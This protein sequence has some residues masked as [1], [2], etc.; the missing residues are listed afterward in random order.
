MKFEQL[1]PKDSGNDDHL[2]PLINIV[3]LMLI[4]FMIAGQVAPSDPFT[5]QPPSSRVEEPAQLEEIVLLMD[6]SGRIALDGEFVALDDLTA[7]LANLLKAHRDQKGATG[8]PPS[9]ALKVDAT[10]MAA[11][12]SAVLDALRAAEAPKIMLFTVRNNP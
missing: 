11:D 2:I 12:L 1:A 7:R 10:L 8:A 4:F 5:V 6:S 3:F 9:I